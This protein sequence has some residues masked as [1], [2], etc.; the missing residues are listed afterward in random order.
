MKNNGC[1]G[2]LMV[3]AAAALWSAS[4]L[5]AQAPADPW[6][7]VV[8]LPTACYSSQ[9][10]FATRNQTA[11]DAITADTEKQKGINDEVSS[12]QSASFDG[13]PMEAA[14]RFQENLMRD[15]QAA[16]KMMQA[17]QADRDP[18]AV[19]EELMAHLK[20]KGE[21]DSQEKQLVQRYQ[22]ALKTA[23]APV[24]AKHTALLKKYVNSRDGIG[25]IVIP[26]AELDALKREM[27]QAYQATC[28]QWWGATGA[29]QTYLK[30]Y[31]TFLV[32][33]RIP[34]EE[35]GDAA[36]LAQFAVSNIDS[37]TYRSVATLE[38]VRDYTERAGRLYQQRTEEPIC[39]AAGCKD[40][41]F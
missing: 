17:A 29:V 21:L 36:K 34:Y 6:T 32:N 1:F 22:T 26:P 8:A 19:Q 11:L 7:R 5:S 3:T 10:Q 35:K 20:R 41:R 2:R 33:E 9:D 12:Q 16:M 4:A 40:W 27:D 31:K 30:S 15:P 25:E 38:A 18:V 23:H 28:P 39:I 24:Q 13:D 14:R 37:K